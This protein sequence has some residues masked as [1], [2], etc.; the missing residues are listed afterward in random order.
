MEDRDN[1]RSPK[2]R[3]L[4]VLNDVVPSKGQDAFIQGYSRDSNP[5]P[6]GSVEY[7]AWDSSW[8]VFGREVLRERKSLNHIPI[9][10]IEI[11]LDAYAM[12]LSH[13]RHK[14]KK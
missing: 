9:N 10:E 6:K 14:G 1:P 13:W 12:G 2:K 4:D 7:F 5:Y 8:F 11:M 3:V